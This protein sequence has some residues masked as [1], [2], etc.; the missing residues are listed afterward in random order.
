M[1][2]VWSALPGLVDLL[3]Y[4]GTAVIFFYDTGHVLEFFV[5][6][7]WSLFGFAP[8]V[9]PI[10]LLFFF[11][12]PTLLNRASGFLRSCGAPSPLSPG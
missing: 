5:R 7:L 3:D 2:A 10:L 9:C 8:A 12:S 6:T 11:F 1:V 4:L